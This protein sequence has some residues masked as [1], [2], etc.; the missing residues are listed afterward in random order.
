VNDPFFLEVEDVEDIHAASLERF[1]GSAGIRDRGLLESAVA[2]PQSTFEGKYLH[3]SLFEMAAA[4]ALHIAESQP[5][6][7][8]NKRTGLGTALVFLKLNGVDVNDPEDRR[9]DG[10]SLS[11]NRQERPGGPHAGTG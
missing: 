1:G 4:Y 7:D 6:V 5:F 11:F 9:N 10:S 2:V 8:G 3:R